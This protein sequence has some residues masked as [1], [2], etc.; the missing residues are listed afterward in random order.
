[1]IRDKDTGVTALGLAIWYAAVG[2]VNTHD[3]LTAAHKT[4]LITGSQAVAFEWRKRSRGNSPG[5]RAWSP[6]FQVDPKAHWSE[7]GAKVFRGDHKDNSEVL[8]YV[9]RLTGITDWARN[10]SREWVPTI[11]NEK[12]PI[13][14]DRP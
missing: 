12:F 14:K 2:I 4:G 5:W 7:Q 1:M 3:Q 9:T 10:K 13:R 11:V 8:A 6:Y